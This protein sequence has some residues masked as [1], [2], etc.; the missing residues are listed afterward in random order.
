[1]KG[2]FVSLL[3]YSM[4]ICELP[5]SRTQSLHM[6]QIVESKDRRRTPSCQETRT[7]LHSCRTLKASPKK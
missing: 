2:Q 7:W 6:Y 1:M 3:F 4:Q 5:F